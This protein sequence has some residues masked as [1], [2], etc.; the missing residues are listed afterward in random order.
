MEGTLSSWK[1]LGWAKGQH[2]GSPLNKL[3]L[4]LIA[5]QA[6]E[7]F[8]CYPSV[9]MLAEQ[10]EATPHEVLLALRQME[11]A[12]LIATGHAHDDVL[13]AGIDRQAP[14]VLLLV[15]GAA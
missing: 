3:L 14:M 15:D 12:G 13:E 4:L 11:T 7:Q 9:R 8:R 2:A 1:A 6:G 10:A 5:Q